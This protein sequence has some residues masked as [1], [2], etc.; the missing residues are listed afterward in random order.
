MFS[1]SDR[2]P[3]RTAM[4]R[5][6]PDD[7]IDIGKF[8]STMWRGKLW[9][10]LGAV[11]GL[12]FG[13]FYGFFYLQPTYS[14]KASIALESRE[15]QVTD[16]NAVV[17]GLS[18]DTSSLNTEI[19]VMRSRKLIKKLV[20]TENLMADP[21]F[22]VTL[23]EIK[24]YSIRAMRVRAYSYFRGAPPDAPSDVQIREA[25]I[26]RVLASL[27]ITNVRN[28]YVFE[29]L[30]RTN[31]PRKSA[32]LANSLAEIYINDQVAV[33]FE[34]TERATAWLSER[35]TQLQ[36]EL[37]LAEDRVKEFSTSTELVSPE[38]L[39]AA[40]RQLKDLRTRRDEL[41]TA[42]DDSRLNIDA[43]RKTSS[44]PPAVLARAEIDAERLAA[45]FSAIND[46]VVDQERRIN[47]Q[48]AELVQLQQFQR[49]AEA[50]R[51]IYEYFLSRLKETSVQQGIQQAD[52]RILSSAVVPNAPSAPRKSLLAALFLVLGAMFGAGGVLIRE[53]SQT[54][55]RIA[56]ELEGRTG[57]PVLGQIPA[58]PAKKR[59][60]LLKYLVDKPTSA[61]AEAVRNLRVSV[62]LSNV[63]NP[64]QVIMS[65]SSVPGEGK[66]TQ[67][68]ALAFNLSGLGKRVLLVE[69]DIR[70]RVFSE[71]FDTG[72]KDGGL[73]S[74]LTGNRSLSDAVQ[75]VEMLG[76]DV[77]PSEKSSVNA[78]DL[79]SSE[80][81]AALVREMRSMYDYIVI[82]TPPVLVVP[83]ARIVAQN[84]DAVIF[85]VK[86]DAT[87]HRQ[88]LDG[89]KAFESV[90]I[91]VAGLVLA[92]I[93]GQGMKKYG[94]GQSYGAYHAYGGYYDN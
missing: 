4:D 21:E 31:S 6:P 41:Q 49:E 44:T 67:S 77:L 27:S 37:E 23:R 25:T 72:T 47:V 16:L 22:N 48:S 60:T 20:E 61:A 71:Y 35:V 50:S 93:S 39:V 78:A 10:S 68:I 90:N 92:Q 29:I 28:S 5:R 26:D 80:K 33:K 40:N 94:Y 87:A 66:T 64:P 46:S 75:P 85:T 51:L 3:V 2:Q 52:S 8:I 53:L 42:L 65:T 11:V 70:R 24:P 58:I 14:A 63:D 55:F 9:I 54:T 69:G 7:E 36:G 82:D 73:I 62:L 88:V 18:G 91:R 34:A 12:S 17:T 76:I 43:L 56:D 57:Y 89:L 19:E 81:F 45:Q 30:A 1:A 38:D 74:V 79:F 32:E 84:V 83:D 15:A 59:A 86:W 13:I